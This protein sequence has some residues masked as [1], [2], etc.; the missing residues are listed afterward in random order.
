M[1]DNL[2][3]DMDNHVVHFRRVSAMTLVRTAD[4]RRTETPNGVMTTLASPTQGGAGLA[5]WRVDMT[6]DRTGPLHAFDTEQVWSFLDGAATVRIGDLDHA[7]GP[8]DVVVIPADA[9]R[10]ITTEPGFSAVVSAPAGTRVYDPTGA[11]FADQCDA[12]PKGPA[13]QVPLWAR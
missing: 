10:Q 7:V 11:A 1:K 4:G 8:G 2:V 9:P 3:D 5:V 13:P 6:P 12:A